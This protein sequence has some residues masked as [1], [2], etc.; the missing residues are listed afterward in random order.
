MGYQV[1]KLVYLR[2]IL[3]FAFNRGAKA[4]EAARNI[5]AVYGDN[6]I[7][8]STARK[9]FPR[10]K[11]DRFDI[12]DT[13]RS[14]RPSGFDEDRLNTLIHNDPRQCTRELANVMNCDHSTIE[15]RLHSMGKVQKSCI[16]IPHAQSQKYKNQRLAICVSLLA[17]HRLTREQHR[18]F[19]SCVVTGD[20]KWPLYANI[21]NGKEW[22]SPNKRRISRKCYNFSTWHA[23][24]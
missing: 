11:E 23:I 22:M 15:W 1:E 3:L 18:S 12:S 5:F 9:W 13:P 21:R 10:F 17:R 16:W 14:G 6:A 8:D 24:F 7:G 19:L 4:A 2:H 20:E